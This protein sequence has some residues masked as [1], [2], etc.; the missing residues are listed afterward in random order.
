VL[1]S[2]LSLV[3][4]AGERGANVFLP[5]R[6]G[7]DGSRD[8]NDFFSGPLSKLKARREVFERARGAN[9]GKTFDEREI[10]LSLQVSWF[11]A[12]SPKTGAFP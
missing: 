12:V 5:S 8:L 11:F 2:V 9:V 7:W 6:G 10:P 3:V 4:L 1:Y